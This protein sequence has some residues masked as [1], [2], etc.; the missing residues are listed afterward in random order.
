M[1]STL[2]RSPNALPGSGR[3]RAGWTLGCV[4]SVLC[5]GL[6]ALCS[7]GLIVG[8]GY[9]LSATTGN[10]G[11]VALGHGTYATDG[12]AVATD[13]DDWATATYAFGAVEKV[14]IRVTPSDPTTPVFVG[15]ARPADVQRYLGG[16]QYVTA[17]GASG[18]RV[19]YTQHGGQAPAAPP[20]HAVAWTVAATGTGTQ[21]LEF[22]AQQ[23]RGDQ[24]AVVMNADGSPSVRGRAESAVT[25]PSLPWIAGGLLAGAV[26]LGVGA[27]LLILK[28][29]RRMR[30]RR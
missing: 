24:V 8:G 5:G 12:Y 27:T 19:T 21:T 18:N 13:P 26:A 28:P 29:I 2:D 4:V 3:A 6:L 25:A 7:L 30:G 22:D 11:W 14:R 10:G 23:Q 17:H 16:V 15:L 20:A 1:R 9:L